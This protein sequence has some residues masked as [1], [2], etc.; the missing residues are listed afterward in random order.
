MRTPKAADKESRTVD[1]VQPPV[2]NYKNKGIDG[3]EMII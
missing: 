3:I 1:V 2:T